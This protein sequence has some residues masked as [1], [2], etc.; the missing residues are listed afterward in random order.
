[1]PEHGT[2]RV[3]DTAPCEKSLQVAL[4]PDAVTPIRTE[5]VAEFQKSAALPGFRKGK[6]PA[7]LV[8]RQYAQSI[9]DE[10]LHRATRRAL[11]T[12]ANEHGLKPVGPFEVSQAAFTDAGGLTLAAKVEVEPVFPLGAY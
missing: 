3:T 11:E 7:E 4:G 6:A 9:E 5:V 12:A 1:L 2:T 8:Q 10:T